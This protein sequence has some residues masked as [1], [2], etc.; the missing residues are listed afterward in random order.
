MVT[1]E[2]CSAQITQGNSFSLIL[3][4][5]QAGNLALL[6]V[7]SKFK[8]SAPVLDPHRR[9]A[10]QKVV[11]GLCCR[12]WPEPNVLN[13][14]LDQGSLQP[15]SRCSQASFVWEPGALQAWISLVQAIS[16]IRCGRCCLD[17]GPKV[18]GY[19]QDLVP[20]T[21]LLR[22]PRIRLMAACCS[23]CLFCSA[24]SSL[25]AGFN[26]LLSLVI[27]SL[28]LTAEGC[29]KM[30]RNHCHCKTVS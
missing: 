18:L 7:S 30:K 17:P 24:S 10:C 19:G 9:M 6:D 1:R 5:S 20:A 26:L 23:L 11:P 21:I 3:L 28:T 16:H 14:C 27:S 22:S 13:L 25:F 12:F 29:C 4:P 2:G 15:L 8:A